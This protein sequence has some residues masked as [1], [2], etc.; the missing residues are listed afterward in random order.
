MAKTPGRESR[1]TKQTTAAPVL[2]VGWR[3]GFYQFS[4]QASPRQ[5]RLQQFALA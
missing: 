4:G 1:T 5:D 3:G 2:E